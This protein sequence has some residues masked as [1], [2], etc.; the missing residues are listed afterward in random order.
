M[1]FHGKIAFY[2]VKS[3]IPSDKFICIYFIRRL[4]NFFGRSSRI[5]VNDRFAFQ[6]RIVHIKIYRK[7]TQCLRINSCNVDVM[8]YFIKSVVPSCEYIVVFFTT[9]LF[10]HVGIGSYCRFSV[11]YLFAQSLIVTVIKSNGIL[12][13]D[14][15]KLCNQLT[16]GSNIFS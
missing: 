8:S 16:V 11:I 2:F 4:N 13:S 9:A 10:Q 1:S 5:S 15:R 14:R 12:S 3:N 6:K 7:R